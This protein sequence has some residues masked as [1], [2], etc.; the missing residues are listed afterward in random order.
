MKLDKNMSEG[1]IAKRLSPPYSDNKEITAV[2]IKPLQ[3]GFQSAR[4]FL[5]T[6]PYCAGDAMGLFEEGWEVL[7]C[8]AKELSL[9]NQEL[10]TVIVYRLNSGE[11]IIYRD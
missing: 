6:N 10:P 1:E 4:R 2:K 3:E 11:V 7:S 8:S 5:A 9:L